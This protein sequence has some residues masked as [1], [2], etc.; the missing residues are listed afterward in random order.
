[1]K[2]ETKFEIGDRVTDGVVTGTITDFTI[3][4]RHGSTTVTYSLGREGAR[5]PTITYVEENKLALAPKKLTPEEAWVEVVLAIA[6]ET[7]LW[8]GPNGDQSYLWDIDKTAMRHQAYAILGG[9]GVDCNKNHEEI[10]AKLN[11]IINRLENIIRPS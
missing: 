1:M 3:E 9:S 6:K 5:R 7:N 11:D 8:V 4:A 10:K 2:I